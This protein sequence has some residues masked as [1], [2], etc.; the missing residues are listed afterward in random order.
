MTACR[1]YFNSRMSHMQLKKDDVL[2]TVANKYLRE[3][4]VLMTENEKIFILSS[5]LAN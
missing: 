5:T 1:Y 4:I 2:E 3:K